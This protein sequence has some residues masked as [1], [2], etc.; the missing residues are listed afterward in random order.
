MASKKVIDQLTGIEA[1]IAAREI[2]KA[3]ADVKSQQEKI[4]FISVF[5]DGLGSKIDGKF[6]SQRTKVFMDEVLKWLEMA[7]KK[8]SKQLVK[9]G[10][11]TPEAQKEYIDIQM[12]YQISKIKDVKKKTT[13]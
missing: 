10:F 5:V 2:R 6:G 9:Q 4:E 11:K 7:D 1:C 3:M 13:D 12:L 8:C